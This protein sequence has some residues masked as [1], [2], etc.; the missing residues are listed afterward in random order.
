MQLQLSLARARKRCTPAHPRVS[1]RLY[2]I[3]PLMQRAMCSA[4]IHQVPRGAGKFLW[5]L[6]PDSSLRQHCGG[7]VPHP[8]AQHPT[9]S[10]G[11][12]SRASS[13]KRARGCARRSASCGRASAR[14]T[15]A[16]TRFITSTNSLPAAAGAAPGTRTADRRLVCE[17]PAWH[18]R[19]QAAEP[20][21]HAMLSGRVRQRER[22]AER[23]QALTSSAIMSLIPATCAQGGTTVTAAQAA[24][25]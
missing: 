3:L 1:A 23:A 14:A 24:K 20:L 8:L 21:G 12:S 17:C 9:I 25:A 11:C 22:R 6:G 18:Q 5:T 10:S 7:G 19:K 16:A 4:T 2:D 13:R 15:A